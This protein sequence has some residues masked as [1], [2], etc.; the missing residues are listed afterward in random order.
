[1][2]RSPDIFPPRQMAANRLIW[3]VILV[4]AGIDL[5]LINFFEL[6][7]VIA[8]APVFIYIFVTCAL[9]SLFYRFVMHE[10]ALFLFGETLAQI[11]CCSFVIMVTILIGSRLDLPLIDDTLVKIDH[12]LGFDWYAHAAWLNDQPHWFNKTLEFCYQSY[13]MQAVILVPA[14]FIRGQS[15]QAQRFVMIFY[16]TGMVTSLIATFLP[17]EAMYLHFHVD[18][19]AYPNLNA[20]AARLHEP[21]LLAMR[22]RTTDVL[23]YPGMG[24]VTFPSFHSTMAILLMYA[25]ISLPFMRLWAIPLNLGMIISTP[26]HGGHYLIDT[27]AGLIIGFYGVYWAERILPPRSQA[28]SVLLNQLGSTADTRPPPTL[29]S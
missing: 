7:L 11:I 5:A 24:L 12:F 4:T 29:E 14:L 19:A 18:P 22:H 6:N 23:V 13:G 27:I 9:I 25:S 26:F 17:A 20:A 16:I 21:E 28:A 15:D 8:Y 3:M 1:M 10:K 2:F